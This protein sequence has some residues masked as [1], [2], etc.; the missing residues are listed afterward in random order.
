VQPDIQYILNPGGS[1]SLSNAFVLGG[2]CAI[3]F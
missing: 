3:V 2:R 1:T